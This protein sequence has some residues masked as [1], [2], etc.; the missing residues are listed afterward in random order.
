MDL[1]GLVEY[2]SVFSRGRIVFL[3]SSVRIQGEIP[4]LKSLLHHNRIEFLFQYLMINVIVNLS[5]DGGFTDL[6]FGGEGGWL[7]VP[8]PH[9]YL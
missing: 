7:K 3:K 8:P 1:G 9:F 2:G 5:Y 4:Y 6:S